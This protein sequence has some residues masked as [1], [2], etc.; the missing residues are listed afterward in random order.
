MPSQPTPHGN[1]YSESRQSTATCCPARWAPRGRP[2]INGGDRCGRT[3]RRRLAHYLSQQ[4]TSRP[5][6]RLTRRPLCRFDCG[7]IS[8]SQDAWRTIFVSEP[9]RL[10][11][12]SVTARRE[13]PASG[14]AVM[15]R[16]L[17]AI[18]GL[19]GVARD[20]TTSGIGRGQG[21]R[22]T[23]VLARSLMRPPEDPVGRVVLPGLR[24]DGDFLILPGGHHL[25]GEVEG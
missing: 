4:A 5:H 16:W 10:G 21:R 24:R 7:M 3:A 19:P 9:C 23:H 18:P 12:T 20:P 11:S 1:H 14:T 25:V 17:D 8:L 2:G 22:R 13:R 15:R 6:D